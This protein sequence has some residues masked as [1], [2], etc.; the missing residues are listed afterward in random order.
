MIICIVL[1]VLCS[2]L[3]RTRAY[4]CLQAP[5]LYIHSHDIHSSIQ[6]T[7][8][9]FLLH[10]FALNVFH[11]FILTLT[12]SHIY[13]YMHSLIYRTL[14][15]LC[16]SINTAVMPILTYTNH[17]LSYVLTHKFIIGWLWHIL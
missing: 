5:T 1:C 6:N 2:I 7:L 4:E 17:N 10:T 3:L 9:V 11:M 15:K 8:C 16:I 14:L 13:S 12:P